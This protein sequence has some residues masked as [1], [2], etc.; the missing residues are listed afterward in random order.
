V[1]AA[2]AE[3]VYSAEGADAAKSPSVAVLAYAVVLPTGPVP[4]T[5]P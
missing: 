4:V 3:I 1:A 2:P 5:V